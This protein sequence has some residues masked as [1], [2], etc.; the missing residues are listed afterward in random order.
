LT[1]FILGA[2]CIP[3]EAFNH[4]AGYWA[5]TWPTTRSFGG[6]EN[7][8]L[9]ILP[10]ISQFYPVPT[11]YFER[12]S[13]K[14]FWDYYVPR[15]GLEAFHFSPL[16]YGCTV[17]YGQGDD[18]VMTEEN[19]WRN[20]PQVPTED[21]TSPGVLKSVEIENRRRGTAARVIKS[22]NETRVREHAAETAVL[23]KLLGGAME[24]GNLEE[25]SQPGGP[26]YLPPEPAEEPY[27]G[28][29]MLPSDL[30][31]L[32]EPARFQEIQDFLFGNRETLA[33]DTLFTPIPENTL[34]AYINR[35]GVIT[36]TKEELREFL[37]YCVYG[38]EI[39]FA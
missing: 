2:D 33:L 36:L 11:E 39:L 19:T 21:L 15:F 4:L 16:T 34:L 8:I 13:Q 9:G 17:R 23:E 28:P 14:D 3:L 31:A 35:V 32:P 30:N 1:N 12:I 37:I 5:G 25:W 29:R 7:P 27:F 38:L 6:L 24:V 22:L 10:S 20:L 18:E 26:L